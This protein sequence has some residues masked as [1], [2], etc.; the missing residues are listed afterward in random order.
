MKHV[1][2]PSFPR[3]P[4]SWKA[5]TLTLLVIAVAAFVGTMLVAGQGENNRASLTDEGTAA[6]FLGRPLPEIRAAFGSM[7]RSGI[8]IDPATA[9]NRA[10]HVSYAIG[11]ANVAVLTIQRGSLVPVDT[12]ETVVLGGRTVSVA[13]HQIR[14]GSVDVG[15]AWSA[16]GLAYTL[17]VNLA[18]GVSRATADGLAAS[19]R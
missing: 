12:Q 4:R 5:L 16:D 8:G 7:H 19:V 10:V 6:A 18:Q 9:Q 17:H 15:Y 3:S 2:A 1:R 14:D 13:S 11:K